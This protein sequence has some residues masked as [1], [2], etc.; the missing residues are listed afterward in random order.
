MKAII[1]VAGIG[2]RLRPHTHTQPKALL[3]VA[4]KAI[5]AHIIDSLHSRGITQF[6]IIIGYLGDKIEEYVRT[7]Y[8]HLHLEFVTQEPRLGSAH[9]LWVARE[10]MQNEKEILIQL[11]D[12]IV[13][14]D[15][16]KMLTTPG[17]VLGVKKVER[18]GLFGVAEQDEDEVVTRLV[19]KPRI[20][21]SNL[22]L[23]GVYKIASAERLLQAIAYLIDND[24]RTQGEYHLTDAL[25]RLVEAGERMTTQT[26]DNWFDCG[27]KEKLL[28]ANAILLNRRGPETETLPSFPNTILIPP[29]SIG[30]NCQI[31]NSIIGPNVAIADHTV[32]HRSIIRDT[33]VG[34]YSELV[35][36]VLHHSIIGNDTSLKGLSQSLN[37]GDDTEIDFSL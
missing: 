20:P 34:H 6:V 13:G 24:I 23:V 31:S 26:V 1:P 9:A 14:F 4:G 2:V 29:V 3:P 27:R 32:V 17:T 18:P 25:M 16:E 7:R 35:H 15:L 30:E 12:T 33:I 8:P 22:A 19:E 28:E 10:A 11:G 36:T 21:K 37:I 5:L